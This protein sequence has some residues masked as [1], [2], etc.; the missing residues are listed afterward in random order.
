MMRPCYFQ[1][2]TR[3]ASKTLQP[4]PVVICRQP[5]PFYSCELYGP[6]QT[7]N[8]YTRTERSYNGTPERDETASE[9]NEKAMAEGKWRR[10]RVASRD[11]VSAT[12]KDVEVK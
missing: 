1:H 8:Y 11:H 2:Y 12:S 7:T 6:K 9:V 10:V 3:G 4:R 5:F